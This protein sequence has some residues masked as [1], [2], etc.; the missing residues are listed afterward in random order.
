MRWSLYAA[1]LG[2]TILSSCLIPN[3]NPGVSTAEA[4]GWRI[5]AGGEGTGCAF[6]DP[7]RFFV[8]DNISSDQLVIYFQAGGACWSFDSCSPTSLAYDKTV[9]DEEIDGYGGVFDFSNP[10]N[11]LSDYDWAFV[12]ACTG[13]VHAGNSIVEYTSRFRGS[14]TI[15]HIGTANAQNVLD[16]V[17]DTY[18]S[19]ERVVVAGS[20]A[21]AIGTWY[22]FPQ[23][24]DRYAEADVR[25]VA[26]GF[27]GVM[28][29]GWDA[30]S[31]WQILDAISGFFPAA[32]GFDLSEFTADELYRLVMQAFPDRGFAMYSHAA[33][34]FQIAY[35][36]LVGGN[37]ITWYQRRDEYLQRLTQEPNFRYFLG[38]G[39]LHTI[40]PF[41]EFYTM[42][43]GDVQFLAWLEQFL[44]GEPPENTR[45]TAGGVDCP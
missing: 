10:S 38:A 41:E 24:A 37:T 4:N 8:R 26:D 13:D 32:E 14:R 42:R 33:D 31:R 9:T 1:L 28:P 17:Y 25:L 30:L 23:I 44:N 16:Y 18:E 7:F 6:G 20:S 39:V 19:P 15:N 2:C 5:I 29:P 43:V 40:L 35:Y 11:P 45:C 12:P 34:S 21:G 36:G 27:I 3:D 22:W